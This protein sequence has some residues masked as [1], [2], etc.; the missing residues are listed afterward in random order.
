MLKLGVGASDSDGEAGSAEDGSDW[1]P[2]DDDSEDG[3]EGAVGD[4]SSSEAGDLSGGD[5]SASAGGADAVDD[6]VSLTTPW[7]LF[8]CRHHTHT[9][10]LALSSMS[11][12]TQALAAG[13]VYQSTFSHA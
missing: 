1:E 3:G 6:P 5:D 10:P 11:I 8:H 4:D 12:H 13:M 9:H 2:T 7:K